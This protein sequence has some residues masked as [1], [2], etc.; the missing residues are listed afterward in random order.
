M[1]NNDLISRSALLNRMRQ[2]II[3]TPIVSQVDARSACETIEAIVE[4]EPAVDAKP[5]RY[6]SWIWNND[7]IDW[8][9]GAWVCSECGVR[10]EN[11]HAEAPGKRR[12]VICSPY[13]WAGSQYCPNCGAKMY[14]EVKT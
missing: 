2:V 7:A 4:V 6:G 8:N 10:N 1:R 12:G 13:V 11:I 3:D 9:L 5:V 14:A